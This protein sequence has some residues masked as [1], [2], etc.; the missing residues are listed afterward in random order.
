M[1]TVA[2]FSTLAMFTLAAPF[3]VA[4]TC[5]Y[6]DGDGNVTYSNIAIKNAKK[7]SCFPKSASPPEPNQ[8]A[9]A[10]A[11]AKIPPVVPNARNPLSEN[12]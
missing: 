3:A 10:A 6:V 8:P 4:E 9:R 1:K 2:R 12:Q 11:P 7:I 5:K